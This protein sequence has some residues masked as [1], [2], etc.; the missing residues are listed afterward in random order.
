MR[1]A[2]AEVSRRKIGD[3]CRANDV[4]SASPAQRGSRWTSQHRE[5]RETGAAFSPTDPDIV[6][7]DVPPPLQSKALEAYEK[8]WNLFFGW[9]RP[10]DACE[11]RE[12]ESRQGMTSPLP[13]LM[14][15]SGTSAKVKHEELDFRLTIGRRKVDRR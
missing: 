4:S 7:I 13:W 11:V 8:P 5:K 3:A 6:M 15:C 14:R 10:S 1:S 9:H 2:G 12:L